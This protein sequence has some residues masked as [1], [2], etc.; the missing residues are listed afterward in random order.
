MITVTTASILLLS[1]LAIIGFAIINLFLWFLEFVAA[2]AKCL[3]AYLLSKP[4]N[5]RKTYFYTRMLFTRLLL[6]FSF[7][8]LSPR[9]MVK[10]QDYVEEF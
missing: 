4:Y 5:W 10:H 9:T 8:M 3:L 2:T 7:A 6:I 1:F